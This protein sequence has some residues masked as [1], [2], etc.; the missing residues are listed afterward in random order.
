MPRK[1]KLIIVFALGVSIAVMAAIA[2][3]RLLSPASDFQ[4]AP[5]SVTNSLAPEDTPYLMIDDGGHDA[6]VRALVFNGTGEEL[7]SAGDD[8]IIRIWDWRNGV[9][10]RTIVVPAGPGEFGKIYALALSKD[11]R[12]L[13]VAADTR[14]RCEEE[15]RPGI[16]IYDYASGQ[17]LHTF[18]KGVNSTVLSLSFSPDGSRLLSSSLDGSAT[19]WEW[20]SGRLLHLLVGHTDEIY[21]AGFATDGRRVVTGSADGTLRL[22]DVATGAMLVH[23]SNRI[24]ALTFNPTGRYLIAGPV[25]SSLVVEGMKVWEVSNSRLVKEYP[26]LETSAV[27]LVHPSEPLVLAGGKDGRIHIW[28]YVDGAPFKMLSGLGGAVWSVALD[29]DGGRIGWGK[30][31]AFEDPRGRAR[32]D[33]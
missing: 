17:L 5:L 31:W 33:H 8:K 4:S 1:N 21:A 15:D 22:W 29:A 18:G 30:I 13:A 19:L 25:A 16:R 11:D 27:A 23:I 26:A 20:P 12:Y 10:R 3:W 9:T 28:N 24:G 32:I 14:P 7:I 2:A 6:I